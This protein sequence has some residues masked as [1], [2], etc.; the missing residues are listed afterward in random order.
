MAV[1]TAVQK[2]CE[3]RKIP[4]P[5]LTAPFDNFGLSVVNNMVS[6]I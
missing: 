1:I 3:N 5:S 2:N 4:N 6:D